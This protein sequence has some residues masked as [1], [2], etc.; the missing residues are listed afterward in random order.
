MNIDKICNDDWSK[1]IVT[2]ENIVKLKWLKTKKLK[3]QIIRI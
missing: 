2:T 3:C 1:K